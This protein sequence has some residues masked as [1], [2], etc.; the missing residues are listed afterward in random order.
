MKTLKIIILFILFLSLLV[1]VFYFFGKQAQHNESEYIN[2][3]TKNV[4][5]LPK[6][7]TICVMTYNIGYLSGMTNNKPVSRSKQLILTNYDKAIEIFTKLNPDILAFQEIDFGSERTYHL[8][9]FQLI[10]DTLDM[11][12]AAKAV[13]WDKKYVPFP[14][15]P[16]KYQFGEMYSGQA[17]LSK[18]EIVSNE[19]I[20]LPQPESN[21]FYYNDFY[22]DRL[23]QI[24]WMRFKD[25]KLLI[26]NVHFEAW[27]GPTREKQA[28]IVLDYYR[29]Y[30]EDNPI[31]LMGDFNCTAPFSKNAFS[32]NTIKLLLDEPG[33][34]LV[35]DSSEFI[36]NPLNYYTFNS[37][38][39][40]Q[41]IDYIFYNSKY[42]ECINSRVVH[43][44]GETSD[45]LPLLAKLKYKTEN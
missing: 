24:S 20:I 30:A 19:R 25:T 32:E 26:I 42:F 41:K 43:E 35:T 18:F 13:N 27:D 8:D 9:Q 21:P 3:Q 44:A 1:V 28:A 12:S 36:R 4:Q 40:F 33:L 37:E 31:I 5:I 22:L 2:V 6:N 38:S 23:A 17:I 14:Y 11:K 29:R 39:P 16:I 45:H 15:W 34:E 7:D 10:F